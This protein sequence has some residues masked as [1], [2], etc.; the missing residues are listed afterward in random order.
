MQDGGV[1]GMIYKRGSVWWIK[2][3]R[4]GKPFREST[5]ST[6]KRVAKN[7]LKRREGEIAQ[8]K[9][10]GV[11]FEKVSFE[12][13]A[14][15]YIRDYRIN[16]KKSR[17]RAI[18][19]I[20]HLKKHFGGLRVPEI[21]SPMINAYIE[22]RLKEKVANATINR[23]LAALKRML[24]I[25]AKQTPPVVDRVPYIQMLKENNARQ[26]FFEYDEF[27]ALRDAIPSYLKGFVTFG[28]MVGWRISEIAGITW[29]Q[30][31]RKEGIVRLEVGETKND[32][33]RTIYLDDELNEIFHQQW[34]MRKTAQKLLP[35]V[36]LNRKGTDRIK[37]FDKTWKKACQDAGIG[38]RLF[39]DFRRTAVRNMV[40]SGV[41]ERVAMMVSGHKTR[42][43]FDRYNIVDEKDLRLAAKLYAAYVREQ[44]GHNLGTICRFSAKNGLESKS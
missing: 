10:P 9:I 1:M 6:K 31:D 38:I 32:E 29:K 24:N 40:R 33:A 22:K 39:H 34:E 21:S 2:Y 13:L 18:V 14:K 42:S 8:G 35:Y 44:R 37:R 30:V 3:Y 4:N 43:V 16:Q 25:G 15:G 12:D 36:F 23:E 17:S 19:S 5:K 27:L 26:G 20:K 11:L 28:Y 41:P 7:L